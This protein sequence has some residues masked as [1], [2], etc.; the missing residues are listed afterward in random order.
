M[1]AVFFCVLCIESR[2]WTENG[3][4]SLCPHVTSQKLLDEFQ[5]NMVS[6]TIIKNFGTNFCLV[7]TG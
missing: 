3:E 1:F 7:S 5:L 6:E 2:N 4:M